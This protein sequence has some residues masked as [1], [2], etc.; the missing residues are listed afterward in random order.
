[1]CC[2]DNS[3]YYNLY[4]LQPETGKNILIADSFFSYRNTSNL[5]FLYSCF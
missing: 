3:I 2:S 5:S 4:N 1:M